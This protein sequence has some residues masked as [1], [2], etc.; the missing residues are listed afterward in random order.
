MRRAPPSPW[1]RIFRAARA[2]WY[3]FAVPA[4]I[5]GVR[6]IVNLLAAAG[7]LASTCAFVGV[8]VLLWFQRDKLGK[9]RPAPNKAA[10]ADAAMHKLIHEEEVS[11]AK[12]PK[13]P[14]QVLICAR[15]AHFFKGVS[16]VAF[17]KAYISLARLLGKA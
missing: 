10:D 13:T 17:E 12:K 4:G 5:L 8:L 16:F 11:A 3:F 15:N 6:A 14:K 7:P 1:K 9:P 2:N